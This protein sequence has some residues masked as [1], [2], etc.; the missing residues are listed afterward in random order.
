MFFYSLGCDM[1]YNLIYCPVQSEL[2]RQVELTKVS[3]NPRAKVSLHIVVFEYNIESPESNITQKKCLWSFFGFVCVSMLLVYLNRV[4]RGICESYN[5]T[6]R[7]KF[8][9]E[10]YIFGFFF[11]IRTFL[12]DLNS[13]SCVYFFDIYKTTPLL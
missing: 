7:K 13:L 8:W 1:A 11:A 12:D 10:A 5:Y 4:N 3:T 6:L 9:G 2:I